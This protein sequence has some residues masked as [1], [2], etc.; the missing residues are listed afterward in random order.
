MLVLAGNEAT[1]EASTAKAT[2]INIMCQNGTVAV[3]NITF[4][5]AAPGA[6]VS[7][8]SNDVDG[9]G[10][11]QVFNDSD[12]TPVA[13]LNTTTDYT[14]YYTVTEISGWDA[15]VANEKCLTIDSTTVNSTAFT[16]AAVN[17]TTW[18]TETSSTHTVK[19][20]PSTENGLYLTIDLENVAGKTGTSTLTILGE[21]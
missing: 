7:D 13:V 8:P 4:P 17:I 6:T 15:T 16:A 21:S 12:S 1:Q 9:T 10:S 18:G 14:V 20:T 2:T 3:S 19:A 5:E 11:S